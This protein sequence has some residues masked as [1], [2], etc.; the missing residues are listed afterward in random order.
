MG[1][2]K[3][4]GAGSQYATLEEEECHEEDLEVDQNEKNSVVE[5]T[6]EIE[7]DF[8]D[9]S[10]RSAAGSFIAEHVVKPSTTSQKHKRGKKK[11][12]IKRVSISLI[13]P[14]SSIV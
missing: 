4:K 5:K 1:I 8:I 2:F 9:I 13:P 7:S 6:A 11:R 14:Y 10:S 12:R 3:K